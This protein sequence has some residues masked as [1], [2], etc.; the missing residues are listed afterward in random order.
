MFL[1]DLACH[2]LQLCKTADLITV[3]TNSGRLERDNNNVLF[4]N[5]LKIS[6]T[7]SSMVSA[8]TGFTKIIR[9]SN[10]NSSNNIV[11]S[12]FRDDH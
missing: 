10:I 11:F 12:A 3:L 6:L 1:H 4:R 9:G 8:L 5:Y 7:F 2:S